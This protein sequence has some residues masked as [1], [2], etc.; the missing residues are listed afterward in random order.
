VKNL[1]KTKIKN[2]LAIRPD[3]IGD[4]VL[5]LPALAALKKHL[6]HARI[7][8]LAR[9]LTHDLFLNN[10]N[11]DEI[12]IDEFAEKKIKSL[13]DFRNYVKTIKSKNF[14]V[15][16]HFFNEPNYALLTFL[17][18]IK[19]RIGD[20]SKPLVAW[21][22]NI[23]VFQNWRNILKHEVL[24]NMRLLEPLGIQDPNPRPAIGVDP[25]SLKRVEDLL[26]G[27]GISPRDKIAGMH[28]STGK[29]NKP[30]KA[31]YFGEIANYLTNQHGF[32]VIATGE[33]KDKELI[34]LA[35]KNAK[36][37]IIDLSTKTTLKELIALTSKY[38]LFVG[39]D[40]GP[41]H[42][43]AALGVPTVSIFTSK[44]SLPLR[45]A[46]WGTRHVIVRKRASCPLFCL[47]A[48]C[49]EV[50]CAEEAKPEDVIS[51]V[52][53]LLSGSGNKTHEDAHFDWS[54][55]SF[56][57]MIAYR[58]KNQKRAKEICEIMS[59]KD[60][61]AS[62]VNID[63]K[64]DFLKLFKENNTNILHAVDPSL[65]LRFLAL[66]SGFSTILPVLYIKDNQRYSKSNEFYKLYSES[67]EKSK[68]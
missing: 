63:E 6:P 59:Q 10:P 58:D 1:D 56:N 45:W 7:T 23:K 34:A 27:Y 51:A 44:F 4:C 39:V 33:E 53:T 22:Y 68:V 2:I 37:K 61:N 28:L 36:G 41:Y 18:Q 9:E 15:A 64:P 24:Q 8:I 17:A 21:L 16:I 12:I 52:E 57:I 29:G 31:E 49:K 66:I 3:A 46:P 48:N 14:D 19:Y 67:F 50:I 42:I 43:A 5:M 55:N 60:F 32:K 20:P 13:K 65:K 25:S 30:W 35:Q 54:K 38:S 11:V 47:P 40:T 62:M 26:A